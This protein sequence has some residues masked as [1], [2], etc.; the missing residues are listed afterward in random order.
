M[1]TSVVTGH[2]STSRVAHQDGGRARGPWWV[3]VEGLNGVGKTH[4]CHRLAVQLGPGCRLLSEVTDAGQDQLTARVID[5][6][7]K[8]GATFLRTGHPVTETFALLALKV[9][10]YERLQPP[11]PG[12]AV[13]VEDRGV[14]TVAVYQAA[15]MEMDSPRIRA[16]DI[17]TRVQ[18]TAAAWRPAPDVTLLLVDDLEV[19]L[20]RFC[21]RIG[22]PVTRADRALLARVAD[23]YA[24]LAAAHPDRFRV[25]DRTGR[26]E[27]E[28]LEVMQVHARPPR[29]PDV[30][31][32]PSP[33]P[34]S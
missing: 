7:I 16:A 25:I 21:D 3:S 32:A 17:V 24:E 26:T 30:D 23:L 5:A 29:F 28:V 15:I 11:P 18:E 4:L 9:S 22:A 20:A 2:Q 10:E 12:V 33:G 1:R 14:D 27:E 8:P 31:P 19:C 34:T 6:L 13:V